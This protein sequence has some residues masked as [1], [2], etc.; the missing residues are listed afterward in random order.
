MQI[1]QKL[2][3]NTIY[4]NFWSFYFKFALELWY[5]ASFFRVL[6]NLTA[7]SLRLKNG[8]TTDIKKGNTFTAR[9]IITERSIWD[10]LFDKIDDWFN[11]KIIDKN[12]INLIEFNKL[13]PFLQKNILYKFLNTYYQNIPNIITNK[14]ITSII[15]QIKNPKPNITINLQ[16]NTIATKNYKNLKKSKK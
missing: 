11:P 8:Y 3:L 5:E 6:C 16:N 9:F 2:L 10:L 14:H 4:I 1:I 12:T 15:N 7:K 13:H